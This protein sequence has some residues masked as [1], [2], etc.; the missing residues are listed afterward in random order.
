MP[1]STPPNA[2]LPNSLPNAAPNPLVHAAPISNYNVWPRARYH[3]ENWN[4][5]RIKKSRKREKKDRRPLDVCVNDG[6]P[7]AMPGR[8]FDAAVATVLR[9]V[10]EPVDQVRDTTQATP[11]ADDGGPG[12]SQAWG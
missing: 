7:A 6:A 3:D 9:D 11:E 1:A 4:R 2:R 10:F 12:T 5:K 8:E